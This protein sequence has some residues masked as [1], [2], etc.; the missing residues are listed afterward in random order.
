MKVII[1]VTIM[2]IMHEIKEISIL[3]AQS[4]LADCLFVFVLI[5]V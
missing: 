2:H 1:L 3:Y 5:L 4:V